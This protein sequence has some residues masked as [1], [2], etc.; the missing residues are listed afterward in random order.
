M[1]LVIPNSPFSLLH[2]SLLC[3]FFP[4]VYICSCLR[5][6]APSQQTTWFA[7]RLIQRRTKWR[8][9][10]SKKISVFYLRSRGGADWMQGRGEEGWHKVKIKLF[11]TKTKPNILWMALMTLTMFRCSSPAMTEKDGG[12]DGGGG[13]SLPPPRS[14]RW[15]HVLLLA[16]KLKKKH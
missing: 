15:C 1:V 4:L 13:Q 16:D 11:E 7:K 9:R 3:F 2:S 10:K 5:S 14:Y 8:F 6:P 12:R